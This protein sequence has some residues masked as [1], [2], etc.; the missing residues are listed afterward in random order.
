MNDTLVSVACEKCQ[1]RFRIKP[2]VFKIMKTLRCSKCGSQILLAKFEAAAKAAIAPVPPPVID[3]PVLAT[4]PE[5]VLPPV[6]ETPPPE[7]PPTPVAV[8]VVIRNDEEIEKL[9]S[10]IEK[11]QIKLK[12][13]DQEVGE[14]DARVASLQ[15][16]WHSKELEIREM[17]ARLARAEKEAREALAIRDAF[18]A[19]AKS[20]L[21]AYLVGERDAALT[22]F[23]DLEKK[24]LTIAPK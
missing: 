7:M 15:E 6:A 17:S 21:A 14:M 18:L 1:S 2:N 22:R 23:S 4:A 5:K 3:T 19:K 8:P 10:E 16:L 12:A 20:E 9:N 24:L 11:L 13:A